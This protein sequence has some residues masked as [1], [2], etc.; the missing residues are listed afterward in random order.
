MRSL[1][2]ILVLLGLVVGLTSCATMNDLNQKYNPWVDKEGQLPSKMV[3]DLEAAMEDS[4]A[5][6]VVVGEDIVVLTF[7]GDMTFESGSSKVKKA[8][9][10]DLEK[11]SA[12]M[13]DYL[14]TQAMIAGHTDSVG[15]KAYNQTLS[16]KRAKAAMGVMLA[17]GVDS[18]RLNTVGYGEVAPVADNGTKEGRQQNR[19]IEVTLSPKPVKDE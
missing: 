5:V 18:E 15:K 17:A 1:V 3:K 14:G 11:I 6:K 13:Q 19:R 10:E 9:R 2:K 4:P 7:Q 16:E 12:L 8:A